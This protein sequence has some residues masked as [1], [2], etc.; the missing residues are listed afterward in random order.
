MEVPVSLGRMRGGQELAASVHVILE[1][2]PGRVGFVFAEQ[3]AVQISQRPEGASASYAVGPEALV[4]GGVDVG[5]VLGS[6]FHADHLV[7]AVI[8]IG[9][10]VPDRSRS[11]L[12]PNAQP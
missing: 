9:V 3:L 12:L 5:P 1:S 2:G 4:P 8:L 10:A 11:E 7:E 6:G